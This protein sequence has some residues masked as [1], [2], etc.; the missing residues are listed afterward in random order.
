MTPLTYT[1]SISSASGTVNKSPSRTTYAHGDTVTLTAIADTGYKFTGWSGAASGTSDN[2]N[3][4][5]IVKVMDA[6]GHESKCRVKV[7]GNLIITPLK[8]IATIDES[9]HLTAAR[10]GVEPYTWPDTSQGRTWDTSYDQVGRHEVVVIDAA[11]DSG[12]AVVKVIHAALG[13]TP[14]SVRLQPG[15]VVNF[16]VAGGTS[17]YAW[18]AEAGS[19]SNLEGDRV[20][21]VAPDDPGEYM[22]TVVDGRDV[23]GRSTVTVTSAVMGIDGMVATDRGT[24]RSGIVV[25]GL[26]RF[27]KKLLIDQNVHVELSFPLEIPDDGRIYNTYGALLYTPPSAEP[28]F[29]FRQS[30][31]IAPFVTYAGGKLP[32]YTTAEPGSSV[33]EAFC[34]LRSI[35]YDCDFWYEWL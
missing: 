35:V 22:I 15:E 5:F 2:V 13:L 30:H 12:L 32:V 7:V 4:L 33:A 28:L 20:G 10:G 14:A 29:L 25:D 27:E 34:S 11:G 17:P 26:S 3:G 9:I 23:Y 18:T 16:F 24:I 31:L 8:V 1:L 19:L 6:L 21:Y